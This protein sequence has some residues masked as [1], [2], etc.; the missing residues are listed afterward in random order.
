MNRP[1]LQPRSI[2]SQMTT[3]NE[4]TSPTNPEKG[5]DVSVTENVAQPEVDQDK[6]RFR[7]REKNT[8][9]ITVDECEPSQDVEAGSAA[10]HWKPGLAA[11]FPW[12]GVLALLT[13]LVC[14]GMVVL[15]LITSDN[16]AQDEWPGQ[17]CKF[18]PQRST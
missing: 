13:I 14:M 9:T 8:T 4:S 2:I 6:A 10:E 1:D 12:I 16:K 18:I 15:V 17:Y 11:R 7:S 3:M 5:S